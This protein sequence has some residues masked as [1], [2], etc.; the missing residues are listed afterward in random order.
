MIATLKADLISTMETVL[1]RVPEVTETEMDD[2][3]GNPTTALVIDGMF[4]L[5]PCRTERRGIGGKVFM[6]TRYAVDVAVGSAIITGGPDDDAD[7]AEVGLYHTASEG[8]GCVIAELARDEA[9]RAMEITEFARALN[10][11]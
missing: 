1:K 7:Y 8:I 3:E 5:Y 2:R 10:E 4:Y 9:N 11:D 6:E